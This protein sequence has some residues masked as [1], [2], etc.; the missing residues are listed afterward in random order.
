MNNTRTTL[1]ILFSLVLGTHASLAEKTTITTSATPQT[2]ITDKRMIVFGDSYSDNGNDYKLSGN[3]YPNSNAY[4][5]GRFSNGPVWVEYFAKLLGIN[6]DDSS[7]L[8]DLA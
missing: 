7:Q 2:T 6:P 1:L 3:K 8:I 5:Q 4:Y